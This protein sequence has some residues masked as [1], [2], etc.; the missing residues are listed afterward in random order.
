MKNLI[1]SLALGLLS[2]NSFGFE[3]FALGTSNTNCKNAGQAYTAK[4]NDL[5]LADKINASVI[6]AGVDGDR[7]AFMM[8][9]LERGLKD[10]PN[11]KLVIFEPGPN[12]RNPRFSLG[13]AED[14]LAYLQ[15]IQMP[16]IYVSHTVVQSPEE[17]AEM[18][19]K[20]GA[21]YYGDWAQGI[22]KDT[23]HRQF[24]MGSGGG[25]MTVKGCQLWAKNIL[26]L[27]EQVIKDKNL[28]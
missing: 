4:L 25:H 23:D 26:P 16:T 3:I 11:T 18:A 19:K 24:D 13:P 5:L 27:V 6:N 28:K 2:L 7:P 15:K 22:P 9:R 17:G 14:I 10:Y 20:Y 8:N 1:V 21:Y 12:E